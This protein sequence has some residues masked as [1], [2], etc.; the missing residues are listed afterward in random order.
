MKKIAGAI[1][2]F[3]EEK[4]I[5]RCIKGLMDCVDEIVVLDSF[6]SDRTKEICQRYEVSFFQKEWEGYAQTKNKLNDLIDAD[7]IFS[8]D[9]DEV[10]DDILKE[11]IRKIKEDS[12]NGIY[13]LNRRTN[14]CG[15]WIKYCGWYPEYKKRI[16]PKNQACWKGDFVHEYLSFDVTIQTKNIGGHLEHY[17]YYDHSEHRSRANKYAVLSAQKYYTEK[18]RVFFLQSELSAVVKFLNIFIFKRGFLDG[19]AGF[20]IAWISGASNRLK[21]KELKKLYAENKVV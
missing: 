8:V 15:K 19:F 13:I 4:N 14:Y 3:N 11:E 12:F 10:P 16:F 20:H 9:A 1:I 17:S 5:E 2:T 7:Y 18:R 6:S 21:Y